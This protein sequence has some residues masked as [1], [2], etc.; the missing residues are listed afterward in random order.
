MIHNNRLCYRAQIKIEL[1]EQ[2]RKIK[3][4]RKQKK[5]TKKAIFSDFSLAICVRLFPNYP[6]KL[7]KMFTLF[8]IHTSGLQHT[9]PHDTKKNNTSVRW[10][11]HNTTVFNM[12]QLTL[13]CVAFAKALSLSHLFA[14]V[15]SIKFVESVVTLRA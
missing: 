1:I 3:S 9:P 2:K 14:N 11:Q 4:K 13:Y 6:T 5:T 15:S 10:A 8:Q 7:T 12:N